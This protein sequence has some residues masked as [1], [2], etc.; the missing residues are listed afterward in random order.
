VNVD[1][2]TYTAPLARIVWMLTALVLIGIGVGLV[3]LP[4]SQVIAQ[5]Q[6]RAVQLYQQARDNERR[7][8]AAAQLRRAEGNIAADVRALGP[9]RDES[10][11]MTDFLRVLDADSHRMHVEVLAIAPGAEA[12]SAAATPSN[13]LIGT[14]LV[15]DLRG[16]FRD[17]LALIGDISAHDVLVHVDAATLS[18][19]SRTTPRPLLDCDVQ[20]TLLRLTD[21]TREEVLHATSSLR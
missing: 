14:A 1:L 21:H 17:I 2:A 3:W 4:S 19:A 15:F 8:A 5:R 7:V 6:L 18:I 20:A 12:A 9:A 13:A 10:A 16:R 11:L